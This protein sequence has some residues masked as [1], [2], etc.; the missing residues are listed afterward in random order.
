MLELVMR[1]FHA[2][3]HEAFLLEAADDVAAV[4]EHM[5]DPGADQSYAFVSGLNMSNR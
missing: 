2:N 4:G 5:T 3:E 1:A